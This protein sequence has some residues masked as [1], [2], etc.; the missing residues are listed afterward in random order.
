MGKSSLPKPPDADGH[1]WEL[2]TKTFVPATFVV[3]ISLYGRPLGLQRPTPMGIA[4]RHYK[5]LWC[6]RCGCLQ[7]TE[8]DRGFNREKLGA[9]RRE[10]RAVGSGD[11]MLMRPK[12]VPEGE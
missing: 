7:F 3:G 4:N 6:V 1:R 2:V 10:Y 12:C 11:T 8:T 9:T 5:T